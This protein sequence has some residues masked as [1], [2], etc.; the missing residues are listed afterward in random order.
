MGKGAAAIMSLIQSARL[1]G[2]D[3]HA[4]LAIELGN[5]VIS[6]FVDFLTCG[7]QSAS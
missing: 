4:S 7:F 6:L 3:P 2:H 5:A 1:S